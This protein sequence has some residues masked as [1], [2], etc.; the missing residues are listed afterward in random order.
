MAMLAALLLEL[1]TVLGG[2]PEWREL[3]TPRKTS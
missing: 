3:G 1:A 2:S